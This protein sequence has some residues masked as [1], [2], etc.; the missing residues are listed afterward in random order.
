MAINALSIPTGVGPTSYSGLGQ[1]YQSFTNNSVIPLLQSLLSGYQGN[2]NSAYNNASSGLG[3]LTKQTIT[4][5]IQ[6]VIN[7]M[8]GK[9]M[10]NSSVAGDAISGV[11]SNIGTSL[12][13]NQLTLAG[14]KAN[15]LTSGYDDTLLKA[16]NL[17]QYSTS[18]DTST[19]YR[20]MA[21]LI[22]SMM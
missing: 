4:P 12:L 19:P 13:G 21:S 20:I 2:V 6:S 22:Q 5:A 7:T 9:N 10:L 8:A 15:A 3:T 16:A 11:A 14:N 17:G 18:S 1:G